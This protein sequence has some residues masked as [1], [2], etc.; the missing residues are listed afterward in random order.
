MILHV[1]TDVIYDM[2]LITDERYDFECDYTWNI[3][4]VQVKIHVL[5]VVLYV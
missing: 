5:C 1:I 3:T 4:Y 2:I